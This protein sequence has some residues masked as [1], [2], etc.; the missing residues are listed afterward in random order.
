M[1]KILVFSDN[2]G[3]KENLL[4]ILKQHQDV[5]RIFSL[6]DSEMKE[7]ELSSLGIVGVKGN[8]PYEPKFPYELKFAFFDKKILL[9]HGHLHQVKSGISKLL[10]HAYAEGADIV[11]FGHTHRTYLEKFDK[12]IV[13]NPGSLS[14][15]RSNENPTYAIIDINEKM[16]S[17][18]ILNIYNNVVKDMEI[19][20]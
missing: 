16:V 8:Y 20:W 1:M 12:L 7:T 3:E 9:T 15:W 4:R 5:E 17:I 13:L 2:H 6:G 18:K 11:C 14:T 19:K 10:I